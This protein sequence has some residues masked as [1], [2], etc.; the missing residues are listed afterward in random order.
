MKVWLSILFLFAFTISIAGQNSNPNQKPR[1]AS[2]E[3]LEQLEQETSLPPEMRVRLAIERADIAHHKV[4]ED[5]QKLND[6]SCQVAKRYE[7]KKQLSSEDLKDVG[8]IEKLAKRI[9]EFAGGSEEKDE[10]KKGMSLEEMVNRLKEVSL[11]IKDS[12]TTETRHVISATVVFNSNEA[13]NLAQFI[14]KAP[15]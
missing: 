2:Q 11:K 13:I 15:K 1:P 9:L 7:E 6:L 3:E 5:A 12:L 14:K 10:T 4:V 8:T